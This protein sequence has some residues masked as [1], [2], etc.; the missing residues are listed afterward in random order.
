MSAKKTTAGISLALLAGLLCLAA[1]A[2]PSAASAAAPEWSLRLT[3]T[4]SSFSAGATGDPVKG[5]AYRLLA[6]NSGEASTSGP[7]TLADVLPADLTPA[8][9]SAKFGAEVLPCQIS[10]QEASCTGSAPIASGGQVEMLISVDVATGT[11]GTI[12]HN[13]ATAQGGGAA[14]AEARLATAI[15]LPA[16]KLD[17]ISLPTNVAPGEAAQ[18]D[19]SLVNVGGATTTGPITVTDTLPAGFTP[20]TPEAACSVA[21]QTVTCHPSEDLRPGETVAFAIRFQVQAGAEG[22]LLNEAQAEGGNAPPI[23]TTTPTTISS[24]IA[25]FGFLPGDSGFSAPV[26]SADGSAAT[27]AGAHP[28]Q[29][30]VDIGLPSEKQKEILA[31]GAVRNLSAELPP[32][33]IVNPNS[34]S[35]LCTE[36]QFVT[37]HCPDEAQIG[38]ATA[39][40]NIF[41]N[42]GIGTTPLYNMVPV[43]GTPSTFGFDAAA[44]GIYTHIIGSL[45]SDGDYGL[46]GSS[47]EIFGR[48]A[49]PILGARL[50][51]WGDPSSSSHDQQR[52]SCLGAKEEKLCP[53]EEES[54]IALLTNPV[55]C[56]GDPLLTKASADSWT[57]TGVFKTASYESADLAGTPVAISGCNQLHFEPTIEA[58][59]TTN[60][61]DSP[62]GLDV[63][64]HQP[65]D[66]DPEG[67]AP[68]IVR[69]LRLTL[70]RGMAVNPSSADGLGSCSEALSGVHTTTPSACP[71]ASKLGAVEVETPLL[72]DPLA[73]TLYLAEPFHN[74]SRTLV[75]LYLGIDDPQ[76]GTVANLAGRAELDPQSGQITTIFEGNPQLPI[77]DIHAHLY[78]GAR[79]SL[80]TPPAC[81]TYTTTSRLTPWSAPDTPDATPSDSFAIQASP[82]GGPCPAND[83]AQPHTP[84]F[85]AGTISPQAKAYS[86]FSLRLT[87]ADDTQELSKIETTL[88]SGLT[89]K[90]A[91]VP[92]CSEAQ[93]A[94]AISRDQPGEGAL[95]RSAPSCPVASQLG[96]V[97]VAAGAGPNPFHAAG[98]AYLAGPYKGA[99]L[100]LLVITPAIAGP[101]DLGV[102][103]VRTALRIDPNTAEVSAVSDPLPRII[104]GI[105]L[106]VRQ[107]SIEL[108]R[109]QFTLNP[110]SCDPMAITGT[111]TSVLGP[112]AALS[113]PFQ[114]GGCPALP[115]KP[116]LNLTL[117]GKTKRTSHPTL[118]ANLTAKPGE[119][120]VAR[121]QVKLPGAAFL[122]QGHIG[123]VCTRVQFAAKTCPA[124]SVYGKVSATTPLLDYPLT[125]NVYLRSS[126][127]QLPDLVADLGG[128]ASQPIEIALAGRTDA[129]KGALR[130]TFEAV[131]DAPVSKFH[132][133]LFGGKRGLIVLSSG[134]CKSPRA[135]VKLDA[136]NGKVYDTN[137]VVKTSCKKG[138]KKGGGGKKKSH[139]HNQRTGR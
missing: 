92:Y 59:P 81:A 72:T 97:A 114:V 25:P 119:A 113:A 73:G 13:V 104:D 84:A 98:A 124:G 87:R 127:H 101:F 55:Q 77:E 48:G 43:P 70:P 16:F 49:N 91:G 120:N 76:T 126:T 7:Y 116:K 23:A 79:A 21:A 96:S 60:L 44:V 35:K 53:A 111:A 46:T 74:P 122:D 90:L 71:D 99:P 107:V 106:D 129:V 1:M 50:A 40:T 65:V 132:L 100:S 108:T 67:N 66:Q 61:A 83:S 103:V 5:P 82:S 2:L 38:T 128:P 4:P 68:A 88:P 117:K 15:G 19:I 47:H 138:K 54:K 69:D 37:N 41:G 130:N 95:E 29:L 93:I 22:T 34:T 12:L 94:Q 31:V 62:S 26:T 3:A 45:R 78:T 17:V 52:A 136:Q 24:L 123:T 137:P 115:F 118:I 139:G 30:T 131:P 75:G 57:E 89:A 11:S 112:A 32:G 6:T 14:P 121:A 36:A 133:E 39:T 135:Q 125:G 28:Y 20:L 42:V 85:S 27:Q 110:T 109:N 18:F 63:D 33:E 80:R 134:L 105:P 102:V 8:T 56:S 10:G 9:V 51:F 58:K 64:V 86:P